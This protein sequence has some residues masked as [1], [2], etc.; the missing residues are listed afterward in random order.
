[1][2][3]IGLYIYP[4]M[5]IQIGNHSIAYPNLTW[6]SG[7]TVVTGP[8]GVGKTTLLKALH[9]LI[10]SEE[11]EHI[12]GNRT[13]ALMP[14]QTTWVPYLR[15]SDHV[16]L[17]PAK[18]TLDPLDTL[19]VSAI[20][21]KLPHELSVGQLQRLSLILTLSAGATVVL[22]D[23]PTSALDDD[24]AVAS[25]NLIKSYVVSHPNAMVIA[26]SHDERLKHAFV[27]ENFWSL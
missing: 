13:T 14:Q 24:L 19:G 4:L 26:V 12:I 8:S 17:V 6:C 10:D 3:E 18:A 23:E 1:M 21:H 11:V 15:M 2:V 25:I 27:Q 16:K 7:V 9:G 20:K 5:T 22:L